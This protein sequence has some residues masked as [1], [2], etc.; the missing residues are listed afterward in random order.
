MCNWRLQRRIRNIIVAASVFP[1]I[2]VTASAVLEQTREELTMKRNTMRK[3]LLL[4]TVALMAGVGLASAQGMREGTSGTAGGGAEQHDTS[5]A[6]PAA[7]SQGGVEIQT[8]RKA[9]TRGQ[10]TG[11]AEQKAKA[12]QRAQP[13]KNS[14]SGQSRP[15]RS[16]TEQG[17]SDRDELKASDKENLKSKNSGKE[18]PKA[19]SS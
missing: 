17:S 14:M 11:A 2:Q 9:E 10:A 12:P 1:L 3:K 4:G 18:D 15:E 8:K 19:K 5:S 16:T 7:K 6:S 13:D